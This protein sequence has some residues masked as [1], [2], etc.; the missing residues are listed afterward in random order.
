MIFYDYEYIFR[1]ERFINI[2]KWY[3]NIISSYLNLYF[4]DSC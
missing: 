3:F 1:G 4:D 2:N